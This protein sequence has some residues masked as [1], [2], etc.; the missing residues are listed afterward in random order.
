M[1]STTSTIT[2]YVCFFSSE[3]CHLK[4]YKPPL[5]MLPRSLCFKMN[6]PVRK[7]VGFPGGRIVKNLPANVG[8]A[9]DTGLIP[10]SG[11]FSWSRKWQPTPVFLLGKF[12]EQRS[13][14]GYSPW[15][16]KES[17]TTE[18]LSKHTGKS[19][20]CNSVSQGM[21]ITERLWITPCSDVKSDIYMI[22]IYDKSDIYMCVC[23]YVC[24]YWNGWGVV[25]SARMLF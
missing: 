2:L 17:Y 6:I 7:K 13:L 20:L 3:W 19:T 14:A 10:G 22:C 4:E 12:H 18:W 9:R 8:D 24:V 16:I 5:P 1:N 25:D 23:I 11:R 21:E 15:C